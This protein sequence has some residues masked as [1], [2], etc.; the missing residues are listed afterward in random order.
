MKQYCRILMILFLVMLLLMG[1][2][3]SEQSKQTTGVLTEEKNTGIQGSSEET[4]EPTTTEPAPTTTTENQTVPADETSHSHQW[5]LIH[6]Q[7]PS[8]TTE[9]IRFFKCS[10]GEEK[11]EAVAKQAHDFV[12]A[13]CLTGGFVSIAI[14]QAPPWDIAFQAIAVAVAAQKSPLPFLC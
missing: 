10:C 5:N 2:I 3:P 13:S 7:K 8:C 4:A 9:G 6:T 12:G 14:R 1:C 11:T